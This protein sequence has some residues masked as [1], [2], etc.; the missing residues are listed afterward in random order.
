MQIENKYQGE[1]LSSQTLKGLASAIG[2]C[3][4]IFLPV[5]EGANIPPE[6]KPAIRTVEK[7]LQDRMDADGARALLEPLR[8]AAESISM[9]EHRGQTLVLLRSPDSMH[10]LWA[11][12]TIPERVC[13]ANYFEVRPLLSASPLDQP[14]Y[15]LAL[16]QKRARLLRCTKDKSEEVALPEYT[17]TSLADSKDTSKPDHDQDNMAT[18]A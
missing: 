5:A 2:P 14:F 11:A 9:D 17:A 13:V 16:N 6:L 7:L 4:S 10:M 15:I 3:V 1:M 12:H 8:E 18:G